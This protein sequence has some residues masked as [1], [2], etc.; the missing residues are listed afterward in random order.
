FWQLTCSLQTRG[1]S[2]EWRKDLLIMV[3]VGMNV[4]H[5]VNQRTLKSCA[6]APVD[7]E[8]CP[9]N[10]AG[11]VKVQD[12]KLRSQLPMGL[13]CYF[14]FRPLADR[15]NFSVGGGISPRRDCSV[16]KVRNCQLDGPQFFIVHA[17][18]LVQHLDSDRDLLHLCYL[19]SR[20]LFLLLQ[21]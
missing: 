13:G 2:H 6:H 1:V 17:E 18:L 19:W 15:A 9:C 21:R 8:P 16:G 14:E 4:E 10:L 11:S 5:E 20:I 12:A 3:L 7:G